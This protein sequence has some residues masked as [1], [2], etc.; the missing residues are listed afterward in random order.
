[1]N[2]PM[3]REYCDVALVPGCA[4]AIFSGS[5]CLT[6]C[7][8]GRANGSAW[9]SFSRFELK[10]RATALRLGEFPPGVT[11]DKKNEAA[12]FTS[13]MLKG[14]FLILEQKSINSYFFLILKAYG[15]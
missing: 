15:F 12:A 10:I 1:M 2:F 13:M 11:A 4:A 8:I 5:D 9:P 7:L 6:S 14:P 3:R